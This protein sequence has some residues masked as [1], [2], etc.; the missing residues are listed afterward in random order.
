[1]GSY[2]ISLI[3]VVYNLI[4]PTL[5]HKYYLD[6][7]FFFKKISFN[8]FIIFSDTTMFPPTLLTSY[9]FKSQAMNSLLFSIRTSNLW[10]FSITLTC[11]FLIV[12]FLPSFIP[13]TVKW[14]NLDGCTKSSRVGIGSRWWLSPSSLTYHFIVH[15]II[16]KVN[17][18]IPKT[19]PEVRCLFR[20]GKTKGEWMT[21][22]PQS[23]T[24]L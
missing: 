16:R 11:L 17:I 1:M 10:Y 21:L 6:E 5:C 13:S 18:S 8:C 2:S 22:E 15:I 3:H 4:F 20:V 19:S 14:C 7:W 24:Y 23:G 12:S 9:H